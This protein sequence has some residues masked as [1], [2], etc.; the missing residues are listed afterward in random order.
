MR[1]R[2]TADLAAIALLGLSFLAAAGVARAEDS[3]QR[4][5]A[6]IVVSGEGEAKAVPDMALI[7]LS[8]V[9][10]AKTAREALDDNNKAMGDVLA[11]LKQ[12]GIADR[13]LQT[14]GFG[15]MPQFNY[16]TDT[17]GRAL[18]PELIGYQATNTLTVRVRDLT[19]LGAVIDQ[20]V[21]LGVNQ[22]GDVA[23][24]NDKPQPLVTE[25]R[26]A[27]VADALDKAKVLT[28]AAGVKLGRIVEISESMPR[29]PQPLYRA[30]AMAKEM[31]D[32]SVPMAAGENSY[33]VT[34][35]VTF[36]LEQ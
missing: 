16:P 30:A 23:F 27:A 31:S 6:T 1:L 17:G 20:A 7:T 12:S 32:S 2:K 8:V 14:S 28:E 3:Q 4:R 11:A 33:S 21:T 35:N 15:I 18:P 26:K 36:A 19:R 13:D 24:T 10:Q 25:A 22:G 34:V 9:R 5:E 29:A